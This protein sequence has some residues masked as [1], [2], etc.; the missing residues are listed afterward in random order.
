MASVNKTII[1]GNVGKDPEVRHTAS[2]AAVC[3][4]SIAT[5]SRWKDKQSGE[6][7]ED[8]QWHRVTFYDRLAEIVGEYVRKGDPIYVEGSLKYGKYTDKDGVERNTTEI[9]ARELQLLRAK[10]RDQSSGGEPRGRQQAPS[11]APAP[12]GAPQTRGAAPSP[13]PRQAPQRGGHTFDDIDNDI[14]F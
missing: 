9:M 11:P 7:V 12:R 10:E 2:G 13:A 4:I 5:T 1:L 8:T 3:N 6:T 14:P